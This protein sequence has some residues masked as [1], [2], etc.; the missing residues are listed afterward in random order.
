MRRYELGMALTYAKSWGIRD[1]V[2]EFFQNAIDEEKE[3]PDNKMFY[4][5]NEENGDLIIANKH[6]HLTPA[7]LLMGNTSKEGKSELIGEHGEGY[8]VAT[9]VLLREGKTV[10]IYNN[11]DN[12]VW[13]SR[14]V[15]SRR[16]GTDIGCFDIS[17][18]FFNKKYDLVIK[19]EG[20]TVDEWKDIIDSCLFLQEDLGNTLSANGSQVLLDPKFK[21]KIYVEG[22]Y[23]CKKD[24]LHW[25]YNLKANLVKL[26]RDRGLIDTFD[27]QWTLGSVFK[28]VKDIDLIAKNLNTPDLQYVH[29]FLK[30]TAE[31][32]TSYKISD[33]VYSDFTSKNG[34]DAIPVDDVDEFN[35]LSRAGKNPVMV[36]S[37]IKKVI[38]LR[39]RDYS[40]EKPRTI[41]ERFEDWYT[42]ASHYLPKHL[43]SEI[44]LLW[45]KK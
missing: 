29:V 32:D 26:D 21:G 34:E 19:I 44:N 23:V 14:I 9:I 18:D 36:R 12:E 40:S 1:A 37:N 7:S 28:E 22:L 13:V 20:I 8:K 27:L 41:E 45:R 43:L 5:Y 6:S 11:V 25:G 42:E 17:H 10:R 2:R 39:M 24:F 31:E 3:N 38:E 33:K 30:N 16:Y 35:N 15:K 4:S